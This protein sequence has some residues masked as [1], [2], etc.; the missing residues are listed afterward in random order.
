MP[1]PKYKGSPV[2]PIGSIGNVYGEGLFEFFITEL[3]NKYN[4]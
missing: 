4:N 1:S 2:L 3:R